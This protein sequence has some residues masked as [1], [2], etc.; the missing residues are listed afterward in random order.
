VFKGDVAAG[1]G[2]VPFVKA[3]SGVAEVHLALL[4][5][6]PLRGDIERLCQR[7]GLRDRVHFAGQVAPES[8]PAMLKEG[9]LGHAMHENIGDNMP[10]T[11]PSK[12]F[13]YL[14]AGLPVL[15]GNRGEMAEIVTRHRAGWCVDP[16]SPEMIGEALRE[17]LGD[18]GAWQDRRT[19]A[20]AA[21][22]E[23]CW[24]REQETYLA[25]VREALGE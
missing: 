2:L 16:D 4:G 24:E 5:D 8:F 21:A 22:S 19:R 3:L 6:G 17:F 15:C 18:R 20:R 14:H 11:L 1:R 23:Y 9:D 10:L 7:S 25:Y 13:D 12:L